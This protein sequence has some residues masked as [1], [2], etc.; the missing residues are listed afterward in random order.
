MHIQRPILL[1]GLASLLLALQP[2]PTHSLSGTWQF[3]DPAGA[4]VLLTLAD[5]Y[6]IQTTYE[7]TR[8]VATTG[9]SCQQEGDRLKLLVEFDTGDSSR[10]GRVEQSTLTIRNN[11]LV[12]TGPGRSQT[13][14]RVD[15]PTT[16]LTGLWRITGRANETGQ[17]TAMPRGPRKT[18]KLLTG[19]RFQ[20]VAI[21]PQTKQF[22]GTGAAPIPCTTATI[23]KPLISFRATTAGWASRLPSTRPLIRT[24]GSIAGKAQRAVPFGSAGAV[25]ISPQPGHQTTR[26]GVC[27]PGQTGCILTKQ[28]IIRVSGKIT[29]TPP[30]TF[31]SSIPGRSSRAVSPKYSVRRR[32]VADGP[33]AQ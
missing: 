14:T 2:R 25:N 32:A 28:R 13:F 20:W 6:L 27:R 1:L 21:N 22:F 17:L 31:D 4:T 18:L 7:P 3:R 26:A 29:S 8:F 10:V 15:E 11:Q 5:Q 9:G 12:L 30:G 19:S 23:P 24:N 16:P 33:V